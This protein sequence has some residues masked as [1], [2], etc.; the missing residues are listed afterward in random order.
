MS[1]ARKF[2]TPMMQQ[3]IA[4]KKQYDDCLLFFRLGDFYELFLDDAILGAKVLNITLTKRPRG[5]DGHIPMA[6]V[7]Y[8]A[9]DG[10]IAKLVKAGH[11][12]A[13]CEQVSEP[14]KKG[15]VEREV[16]RIVT[17]GTIL[18][19]KSLSRNEHNYTV[20][21]WLEGDLKN[22]EE[23][24]TLGLA[25]ADVST[26]DFQVAELKL[27]GDTNNLEAALASELVRFLPTECILEASD[28][29]NPELLRILAAFPELNIY[30]FE[31]WDRFADR[32]SE[33]LGEH[34]GVK[35]LEAFGIEDKPHVKRAAAALLGYLRHTQKDRLSHIR[36]LRHFRPDGHLILNRSTIANLELF[37]TIRE[38]EKN[39]SLLSVLDRT[40][41]PMGGRLLRSW[42][43]LPLSNKK[44]IEERHEAVEKFAG[45]RIVR[46]AVREELTPLYDIERIISRLSVGLGTPVDLAH[47]KMSI[48]HALTTRNLLADVSSP[49]INRLAEG[50]A[51]E[52]KDLAQHLDANIADEPPAD[53]RSGGIIKAGANAEVDQLRGQVG[54]GKEWLSGLERTERERTGIGSLKVKFN[55][56]FGYYIEISKANLESVPADYI[57]KQTMVGAERFI[58][59]ELKEFETRILSAE[60]RLHALEHDLF[61]ETVARVIEDTELLQSAA[62][63]L[64]QIDTLAS[65]AQLAE[66][67]NYTRPT[68]TTG[69]EIVI[70]DGRHPVVETVLRDGEFVPNDVRL[71]NK[72]HQLLL[73]TG[74]N[75]AGKSV[76]SRQVALITLMAHLGSFVPA[77]EATISLVDSIFVRSGAADVI[78]AGLSTFMVEMVET[79]HILHH[80]TDRSLIIMDEIGRGTS[81]Y[82]GISIAWAIAEY[83]VQNRNVAAKTIFAT[84]YHELQ[85]LEERYK[86]HITNYRVLVKESKGKPIFLHQV[87]RG[88]ADHSFGVAVARLAGVPE[89]VT[90]NA[91]IML[92]TLE[93]KKKTATMK[94]PK[95]PS[96]KVAK[97]EGPDPVL[98]QLRNLNIEKT[99]PLEAL[100]IIS[101]MKSKLSKKKARKDG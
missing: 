46:Q 33:T 94:M 15:I 9:A 4:I 28:Y 21:I 7:P 96:P 93:G 87:A 79:A 40:T 58:T 62:A 43:K 55:R 41:T 73:L 36:S 47:L 65:F 90:N 11:K 88:G 39:G 67:R 19:E 12:V 52:L 86:E 17:P 31:E 44:G 70:K 50:I 30:G 53:Y 54:G 81:T 24:I 75:M 83:L 1:E 95:Q 92:E 38:G 8:H 61:I 13:I 69:H 48:N 63:S 97:K 85:E 34:F 101:D 76:F 26:G 6:G 29:A 51:P 27:S 10:Y 23:D 77:S 71:D 3:Y 14:D 59:E 2:Q 22:P 82:D 32:A 78:T 45:H 68:M 66:E 64:A 18:D 49:L 20:A 37:S 35:T 91:E 5:K 84:H 25:A 80:T 100:K 98:A 57:R 89:N 72:S 74:P 16:V 56:V 42:I 60:E 99:T